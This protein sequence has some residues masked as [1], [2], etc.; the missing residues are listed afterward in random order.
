MPIEIER[1]FLLRSDDWR[2]RVTKQYAI[3]QGYLVTDG[4]RTVRV[5][6]RD[7]AGFLT[8][9]GKAA[10]GEIGRAE[11]EYGIPYPDACAMLDTLCAQPLIEKTRHLVP[12]GALTVEIDVFAG[13]NTG[14]VL[15]EIEL[16]AETQ[17]ITLPDWL[18]AEVTRDGRY[19]NSALART[20]FSQW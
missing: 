7:D 8:I 14:L 9:K 12:H 13:A 16:L 6:T 17:A 2:A 19:A 18:G 4:Q 3:R 10:P 20:P 5:R 15:A 11:F 1:K